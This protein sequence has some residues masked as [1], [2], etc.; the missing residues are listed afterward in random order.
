MDAIFGLA[1]GGLILFFVVSV[2]IS[3]FFVLLGA[4]MAGIEKA[5]L[6]KSI[7]ASIAGN[8]GYV[9]FA[10]V[11]SLVPVIGTLLGFVVGLFVM[12]FIIKSIFDTT[13]GKAFLAWIFHFVAQVLVILAMIVLAAMGLA[14]AAL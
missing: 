8:I 5:T 9:I 4:K 6:G 1:A 7:I 13:F 12:L 2:V 3:G 14:A 11:F 10:T